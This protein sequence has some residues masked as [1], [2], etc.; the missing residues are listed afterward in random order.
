M[1]AMYRKC[2]KCGFER[3]AGDQSDAGVCPACGLIFAKWM[4]RTLGT[5]APARATSEDEPRADGRIAGLVA[6]LTS[7]AP[8][9]DPIVFWGRVAVYAVLFAWGWYFIVMNYRSH[10]IMNS[11]MHRVDLVFHEAGHVI[12][13]PFGTFMKILGGTLGQLI[14][15]I[16]V[17]VALVVTNRDNF[18]GSVGLWW[19]GQSM[20]DCAPYIADAR[21]LKLPL[22]GGGTGQ[23]RPGAHDW[24]N[25]LLDLN[26]I[27]H[28]L[29][30]GAAV[31]VMGAIVMLIAFAWGGF[32]LLQQYRNIENN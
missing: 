32:I 3:P 1:A 10:E 22:L 17:M 30:I 2:P 19:L 7:A 28:D 18:G 12:F 27:Q 14:M 20:M 16:V 31:H 15:P 9:S 13:I 25:I 4:N 24:E 5:D 29:Q 23:D 26:L 21:A 6:R 11:F 8:Q